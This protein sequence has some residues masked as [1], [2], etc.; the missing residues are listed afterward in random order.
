HMAKIIE[1]SSIC[2]VPGGRDAMLG[3]LDEHGFELESMNPSRRATPSSVAA[4]S[5]YEQADPFSV[6]EPEGVLH[7]DTARYEAID[8]RRVR[9]SGA[10]WVEAT[11]P[12]VKIEGAERLGERVVLLAAAA[13]SRFIEQIDDILAGV[14]KI[15]RDIFPP[16]V[17]SP[18]QIHFRRYGVDGVVDWPAG[19]DHPPRELFLLGECVAA[20]AEQAKSVTA[21]VRQHLLHYGFDGR[22]S[23]GGNLAFPLTPP[24]LNAG[25][26]YRFSIYHI[27]QLHD[28]SELKTLFPVHIETL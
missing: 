17:N 9:V 11:R 19:S 13:D 28:F 14:E 6:A 3:T 26:A 2:C 18:Y 7:T 23:T 15:A 22:I 5:L 25:T 10:R 12:S 21:V 24:E 16:D 1:C 20:T 27:M 4:H 8:D